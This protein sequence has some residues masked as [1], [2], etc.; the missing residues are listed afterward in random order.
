VR[1]KETVERLLKL[2]EFERLPDEDGYRLELSRGRLVREPAPGAV[3]SWVARNLLFQLGR[4]VEERSLGLVIF[5]AGFL[6]SEDPPTVRIPDLAFLSREH[7]PSEGPPL[8]FWTM[9]PD[10]AVEVVSPSNRPADI[11]E[12]V[13]EY[14]EAGTRLVW[15][16]D[17]RTRS[18][19][20]YRSRWDVQ[21]LTEDDVLD[22]AD[23]LP[24]LLLRIF[25]IFKLTL[26]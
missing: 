20:V 5:D 11:R 6:L 17:P 19:T 23:V 14:M 8:G 1:G 16:V 12:K 26:E 9:A 15:V 18:V 25:E 13:F 21:L 4:Y 22:G 2:E 3:H 7:L 10:L 24:G